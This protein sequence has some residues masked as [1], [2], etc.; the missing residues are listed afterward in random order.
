MPDVAKR[1]VT[2][3]V[4]TGILFYHPANRQ[5]DNILQGRIG[6]GDWHDTQLT[7]DERLLFKKMG[8]PE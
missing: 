3:F 5:S 1:S 6:N 2:F 8:M 7:R 4:P